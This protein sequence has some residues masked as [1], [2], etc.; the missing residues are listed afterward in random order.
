MLTEEE[1]IRLIHTNHTALLD[2]VF[3]ELCRNWEGPSA[4][5]VTGEIVAM[6]NCIQNVLSN[7]DQIQ[8]PARGLFILSL[9][10]VVDSFI[11]GALTEEAFEWV[12]E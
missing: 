5:Q 6:A 8:S 2:R 4:E 11:A 3:N 12:A 7:S 1:R 9:Q 10:H